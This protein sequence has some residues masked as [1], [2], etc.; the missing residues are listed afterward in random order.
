MKTD[1]HVTFIVGQLVGSGHPLL[2]QM[3]IVCLLMIYVT[4][5]LSYV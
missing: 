1:L 2:K 5:I 4:H 3:P